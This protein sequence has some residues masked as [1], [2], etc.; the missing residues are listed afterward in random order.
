MNEKRIAALQKAHQAILEFIDELEQL[1]QFQDKI[2]MPADIGQI[3]KTFLDDIKNLI[4]IE[5]CSLFMVDED[6]HEF[7]LKAVSPQN[8]GVIC[9]KE[10]D[11]QIECGMFSWVINRR[12]AA[13]IPSLAFKNKRTIIMLPLSTV[14]TTLGV[15]LV[16]SSI[17]ASSITRENLKLLNML[18]KQCSLVM[19]N[20][21]LYQRLHKE[22]ESLQKAHAQISQ[23]EKLASI[24]RLTSGAFHEILNP[25][26]I[27][28][29][30]IQ[31]LLMKKDLA[32]TISKHLDI[33]LEQTART[34]KIVKGLLQ[35]AHPPKSKK[36]KVNINNL[37][38]EI[39][40]LVEYELTFGK[41]KIITQLDPHTP[42]IRGD[43]KSLSQLFLN[44]VSN[45]KDA[46]PQGG[47]LNIVTK[48]VADDEPQKV[49][50]SLEIRIQDS[51][52]G[53]PE[54]NITKIFDPFFTTKETG[55][56]LGLELSISYSIVQDHGGTLQ[57][58]SKVDKGT[59]FIITLPAG[60]NI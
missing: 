3:W 57:V 22:H 55:K 53:I 4:T 38:K 50:S 20:A 60:K 59:T 30:H 51:G 43:K 21:L 12:Q 44:L 41:I 2:D 23:A 34:A 52:C 31:L 17:E 42:L 7:K 26:N 11:S 5:V 10:V 37:I 45:A 54:S 1:S 46:M 29:G 33:M 49:W 9:Q 58:E 13:I 36:G 25:L 15:V 24:G 16:L 39:L 28:S 18:A 40:S 35:F 32:S 27:I 47:T 48:A 8:R 56:G 14:K 6:T 19:E